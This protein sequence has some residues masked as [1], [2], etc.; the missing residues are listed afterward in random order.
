MQLYILTNQKIKPKR[1]KTSYLV[2]YSLEDLYQELAKWVNLVETR[3]R[4]TTSYFA[5]SVQKSVHELN[6]F[7]CLLPDNNL[8]AAKCTLKRNDNFLLAFICIC[9]GV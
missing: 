6:T 8:S 5:L 3:K 9:G 4:M 1:F 7:E 2:K